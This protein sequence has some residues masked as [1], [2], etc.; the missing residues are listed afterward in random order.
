[1]LALARLKL[2]KFKDAMDVYSN[3]QIAPGALTPSALA[4]HAAVLAA[5]GR[6]DDAANEIRDLDPK[7]LLPEEAGLIANISR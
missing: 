4:V 1:M 5:N 7:R 6:A 2:E 3:V